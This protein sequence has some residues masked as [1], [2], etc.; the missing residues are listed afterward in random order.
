VSPVAD[1]LSLQGLKLEIETPSDLY[2]SDN[3]I[4]A[5]VVASA[6]NLARRLNHPRD[7]TA[8]HDRERR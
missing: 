8:H 6:H 5:C 1:E 4:Y 3:S 7:V 2:R